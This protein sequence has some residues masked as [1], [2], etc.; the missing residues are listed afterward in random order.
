MRLLPE[1]FRTREFPIFAALA[2]TAFILSGCGDAAGGGVAWEDLNCDGVKGPD[3]PP[4]AGVCMWASTYASAP[5][6]SGEDC[7]GEYLHTDSEGM[8]GGYFYS[9]ISCNDVFVFA[10]APE[11][12]DSTTDT[13]ANQACWNEFG[14]APEGT[15]P[16]HRSVT[17][18][19][20]VG[21]ERC[22]CLAWVVGVP[23]VLALLALGYRRFRRDT[24]ARQE[25]GSGE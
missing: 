6:P 24:L 20:L 16:P 25:T 17:A 19:E 15:C 12:F 9:G 4:L 10:Q 11:G 7:A 22:R 13:V 21:R 1:V 5:T 14:F 23:G 2:V 8:G 3:E 18:L